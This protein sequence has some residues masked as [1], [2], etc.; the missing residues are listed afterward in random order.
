MA[1]KTRN[2]HEDGLAT[3]TAISGYYVKNFIPPLEVIRVLN[4]AGV[5][6]MLVGA[7]G[8]GGWLAEPRATQDV[9]V[10]VALRQ[11]HKAARA[12]VAAFP[13]LRADDQE[14]VVRLLDGETQKVVIDIMKAV[15]PLYREGLKHTR[16]VEAEGETYQVPSL[17]M[18]L[19]MK[20]GPMVSLTHAD[21]KK[22][23][24]ASDFISMVKHNAG[25]DLDKLAGLGDLVYPGGGKEIVEL[26][27]KVLAGEKLRLG[28]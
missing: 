3:S 5:R 28:V 2:R 20:F 27:R 14:V 13:R 18:A 16:T 23:K 12:L 24:D 8:I 1:T 11:H 21:E 7:H 25:I 9:D 6:F 4:A 10:L 26:V 17:E 19:A 22:Y 15:Q